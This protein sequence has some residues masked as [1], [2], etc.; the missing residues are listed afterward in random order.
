MSQKQKED[1]VVAFIQKL[2]KDAD[3]KYTNPADNLELTLP[4][5]APPARATEKSEPN[6]K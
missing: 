2:K 6:S 1:I 3:I 4:Q 5:G